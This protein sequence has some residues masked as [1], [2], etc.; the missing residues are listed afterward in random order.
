MKD[1]EEKQS[2]SYRRKRKVPRLKLHFPVQIEVVTREGQSHQVDGRTVEVSRYGA[3]LECDEPIS[4][5]VAVNLMLPF[6]G[7]YMAQ[8]NGVW[9]EEETGLFRLST[10]LLDPPE[11]TAQNKT[12]IHD[13]SQDDAD[14]IILEP[15]TYH[16]LSAYRDYLQEARDQ[17]QT[18]EQIA[19]T[20]VKKGARSDTHFQKWMTQKIMEDLQSWEEE[21]VHGDKPE[22]H[23]IDKA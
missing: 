2:N 13:D 15:L 17:D 3:T 7:P 4:V 21:S 9:M 5:K 10:K 16:L 20:L 6:G 14:Q 11:W 12:F 8:V 19:Q 1:K 18:I 22:P 23:V